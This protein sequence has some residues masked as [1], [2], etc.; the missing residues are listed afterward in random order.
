MTAAKSD[1]PIPMMS[2]RRAP[3]TTTVLAAAESRY[4]GIAS[5]VNNAV[6][7]A[8]G[9]L[10][11][12]VIPVLAGISGDSYRHP[13]AFADGFHTAVLICAGLLIAGGVVSGVTIRNPV[14]RNRGRA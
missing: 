1:A 7:R 12:A 8:A 9:L 3:L 4:A 5:G 14:R 10:A 13:D 2:D 6:A 11:V